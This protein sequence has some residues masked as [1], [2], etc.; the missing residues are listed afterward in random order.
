MYLDDVWR[1]TELRDE[2]SSLDMKISHFQNVE[3]LHISSG[4]TADLQKGLMGSV[5][6]GFD[7][8]QAALVEM[9]STQRSYVIAE[10][11]KLGVQTTSR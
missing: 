9:F 2:L 11:E 1:V 3:K 5:G 6:T 10:L 7:K 4:C 8:V